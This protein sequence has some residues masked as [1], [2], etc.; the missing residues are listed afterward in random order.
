VRP[1]HVTWGP[2]LWKRLRGSGDFGRLLGE[3]RLHYLVR[4][5][6]WHVEPFAQ[7]GILNPFMQGYDQGGM[8]QPGWTMAYNGTGRPEYVSTDAGPKVTV[9]TS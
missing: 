2:R 4:G 1:R 5:E 8:L 3:F 9:P 6:P 7:G